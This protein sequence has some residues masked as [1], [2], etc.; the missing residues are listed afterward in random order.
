MR[1]ELRCDVVV[2]SDTSVFNRDTPSLCT[3]MRGM[4][5]CQVDLRGPDGDL[6]SGSF[7]GAVPNP[8]ACPGRSAQRAARRGGPGHARR[9][10]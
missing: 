6:H 10:L 9:L 7:G 4:L 2:V 3:G 8:L 1:E 5:D